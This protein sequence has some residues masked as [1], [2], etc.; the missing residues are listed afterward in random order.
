M[1][2]FFSIDGFMFVSMIG[3][4]MDVLVAVVVKNFI[5]VNQIWRRG[6]IDHFNIG[7]FLL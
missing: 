5:L 3:M 4:T 6:S 2:I 7:G 1:S